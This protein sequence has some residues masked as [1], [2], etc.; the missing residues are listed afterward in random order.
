MNNV[1]QCETSMQILNRFMMKIKI[2]ETT[3]IPTWKNFVELRI[4]HLTRFL[5]L[6]SLYPNLW[7]AVFYYHKPKTETDV[8]DYRYGIQSE[9]VRRP[10][11][12]KV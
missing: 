6:C 5:F 1:I 7:L 4:Y 9:A 8:F 3:S 2:L 12:N 11:L 10:K